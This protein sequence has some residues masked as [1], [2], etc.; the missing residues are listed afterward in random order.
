MRSRRECGSGVQ[1]LQTEIEH[2]RA[3]LGAGGRALYDLRPGDP[4]CFA[5]SGDNP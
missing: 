2:L 4:G 5:W 1:S 3:R